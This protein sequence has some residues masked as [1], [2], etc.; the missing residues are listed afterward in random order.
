MRH[1]CLFLQPSDYSTI[2]KELKI[3]WKSYSEERKNKRYI[4]YKGISKSAFIHR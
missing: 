3:S 2:F 4:Y 1:W